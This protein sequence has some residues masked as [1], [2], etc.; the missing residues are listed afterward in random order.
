MYG[1]KKRHIL[2]VLFLALPLAV[3]GLPEPSREFIRSG[4]A[5]IFSIP[6]SQAKTITQKLQDIFSTKG[7][8]S[9]L[10]NKQTLQIQTLKAENA[11]LKEAFLENQRLKSLVSFGQTAV[12]KT[13]PCQAIA[14]DPSNWRH[15]IIIN[16]GSA[17]GIK[18]NMFLISPEGLTGRVCE[19]GRNAAKV[20]L[21]TD[22]DFKVAGICQRSREQMIVF[23]S[24]RG[25]CVLKYLA[26]DADLQNKDIIVT[27][28][29]G[30]FCPKG[31]IIGEVSAVRKSS[32]G[33][34]LEAYLKP[35]AH[36]GRLEE[37]LVLVE[38]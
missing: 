26:Q 22:P 7:F 12:F 1:I 17:S 13:V 30:G 36:L 24:G 15:T 3:A 16:K 5:K 29:L 18:K 11:F 37:A 6:L 33:F 14:R 20:I 4:A 34:T 19:A 2:T 9:G 31:I 35:A 23:G 27:S 10:I 8:F 25:L 28:G 38:Q 32:D 21:L